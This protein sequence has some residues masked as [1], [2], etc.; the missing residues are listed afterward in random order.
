MKSLGTVPL[1]SLAFVMLGLAGVPMGVLADGGTVVQLTDPVTL[2]SKGKNTPAAVGTSVQPGDTLSTGKYGKAQVRFEDDS[3]FAVVGNSGLKVDQ[4]QRP[5]QD[6]SGSAI[7]SLLRGGFRTITGLI[8]KA[9]TDKYEIRTPVATIGVRGSAYSAILCQGQCGNNFK[10]GL[11]VR[12]E[13]GIIIVTNSGGKIELRA[14]QAAYAESEVIA[15][16]R[17]KLSPFNDPKFS[18][19]FD[20][21]IE[22][23][24]EVDPPR[25]EPEPPAS[26][27]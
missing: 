16:I 15:P 11:F 13:K 10:D 7:F 18:A 27:S 26:P 17:V 2:E 1:A 8:G 19:D 12:A 25:I 24:I 4:F 6:S 9:K 22:F 21:S 3:I 14:G 23:D 20:I 5:R